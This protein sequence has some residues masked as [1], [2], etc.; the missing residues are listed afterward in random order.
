MTMSAASID[1]N[2][3]ALPATASE[4]GSGLAAAQLTVTAFFVGFA[5]GQ[6]LAGPLA[7]RHGRRPVLLAGIGLYVL[8]SLACALAPG[9]LELLALR[10]L[11]GLAASVGPVLGRAIVRDRFEGA[12]M[13]RVLSLAMAVFVLAPILAPSAGA[14]ILETASWRWIFVALA[15]YG[16][17]LL[18]VVARGLEETLRA[19]D[20]T[21]LRPRRIAATW[22]AV[23]GERRS[24]PFVAIGVL[25]LSTL[26]LY[27]VSA[28]ALFMTRYGLS[29]RGFALVFAVVGAAAAAGSLLNARLARRLRLERTIAVGLGLG[30]AATLG[31]LGLYLAGLDG[32][33]AIVPGLALFFLAFGLVAANAGALAL[34]PHGAVAGSAAGVVGV[35]QTVVPGCLAGLVAVLADGAPLGLLAGMPLL[36]VASMVVLARAGSRPG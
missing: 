5:A 23:L 18:L 9:I 22:R 26:V 16:G 21:A 15:L 7:D 35:L 12:E 3:P 10:L 6:A 13:A 24:R 4:L 1:I 20:P 32:P 11:Q 25:A 17:G 30:L 8:A 28:P 36:L 14:L 31:N 29:P 19:P 33:R 2:L 27:L 34:Q